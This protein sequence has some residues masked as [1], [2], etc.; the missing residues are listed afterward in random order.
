MGC[1]GGA[2]HPDDNLM[3]QCVKTFCAALQQRRAAA[4]RDTR[5][6]REET[7]VV[8]RKYANRRLYDTGRSRYVNLEEIAALIRAGEDVRVEDVDTGADL[9]RE[10]LLQI[11]LDVLKGGEFFPVGML[12]RIIR[13]SGDGPT[14]AIVRQQLT[15]GLEMLVTQMDRME[16]IFD[17]FARKDAPPPEPA[18]R[19]PP[20]REDDPPPP[21]KAEREPPP[22]KPD[23]ELDELRARLAALEGRLKR[24]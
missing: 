5:G 3:L 8:I 21:P 13:A 23:A 19:A 6:A 22:E 15:T 2:A 12:R 11:V 16:A 7:L 9:T 18:R 14:H 1:G 24:G 20:P 4:R 17:P 10:I